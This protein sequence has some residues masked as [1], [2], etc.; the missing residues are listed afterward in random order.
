MPSI[1]KISSANAFTIDNLPLEAHE[2]FAQREL[3]YDKT[4]LADTSHIQDHAE[5]AVTSPGLISSLF[6][7]LGIYETKRPWS[8]FTI[9]PR[10]RSKKNRFFR[11][12]RLFPALHPPEQEIRI[13]IDEI[14]PACANPDTHQKLKKLAEV[15]DQKLSLLKDATA[16]IQQFQKG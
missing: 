4:L 13:L 3:V 11:R 15:L 10:Y 6:A 12:S 5:M 7:W 14:L 9:P 2:S 16:R 8:T 1:K